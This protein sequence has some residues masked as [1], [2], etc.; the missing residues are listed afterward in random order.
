MT[1]TLLFAPLLFSFCTVLAAVFLLAGFKGLFHRSTDPPA[2]MLAIGSAFGVVAI[3]FAAVL[4]PA[5]TQVY[6]GG[7]NVNQTVTGPGA[8]PSAS[9]GAG[10][11]GLVAIVKVGA[12]GSCAGVTADRTIK[13]GCTIP[14]TCTPKAADGSLLPP[15]VT[16]LAPD[17]FGVVSGS[18]FVRAAPWDDE[19]YNLNVLG[20]GPGT[21]RL[22]CTVK[23]KS[24]EEW[25]GTVVP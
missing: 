14:V 18:Q 8:L 11:D 15:V 25:E 22:K 16:G 12:F 20:V 1:L 19:A 9:P 10:G 23:G 3:V 7:D 5:C 6:T 13:V 21:F 2:V 4:F 24:S 17:F